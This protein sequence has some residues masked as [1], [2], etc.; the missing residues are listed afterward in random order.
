MHTETDEREGECTGGCGR[1][2]PNPNPNPSPRRS[3]VARD[4]L[5]NCSSVMHGEWACLFASCLLV[6]V[7]FFFFLL[8]TLIEGV[9]VCCRC[10]PFFLLM[11]APEEGNVVVGSW[12]LG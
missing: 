8:L 9:D 10:L 6:F 1:E 4:P 5:L 3:L 7:P 12:V 2:L 11:E